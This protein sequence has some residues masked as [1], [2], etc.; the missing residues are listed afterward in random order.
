MLHG[1][2]LKIMPLAALL[3]LLAVPHVVHAQV[4]SVF[5]EDL[6]WVEVDAALKAGK[7]TALIYTGGA[8]Q[9]G[10]HLA[11]GKHNAVARYLSER[12]AK[13]LGNALVYPVLP[14]TPAGDPSKKEGQF[15]FPGTSGITDETYGMV[16]RDLVLGA[17]TA[18]FQD[19]ILIG[20]HGGGQ[21]VLK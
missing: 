8:E 9:N 10:P 15:A 12:I 17:A 16:L 6:T 2:M 14:Y 4:T 3:A 7:T 11:F 19:I 5:I 18:G 20:D 13:E 21:D 1:R